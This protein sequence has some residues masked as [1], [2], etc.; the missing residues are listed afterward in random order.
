MPSKKKAPRTAPPPTSLKGWQQIG[1]FLGQPINVAQRWAKSG[2]PTA[3]AGRYITASPEDLN[4]WLGREAGGKPL[5]VA[6]EQGDLST[7][8]KRGLAYLKNHKK[9]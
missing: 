7:D 6:T 4:R 1:A 2:M 5:H 9:R 8:L 3:R